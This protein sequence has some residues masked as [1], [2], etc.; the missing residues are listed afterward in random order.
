MEITVKNGF[1]RWFLMIFEVVGFLFLVAWVA[2]TYTASELAGNP[3]VKNLELSVT[4]DP[5]NAEYRQ[6][7]GLLYEYN[8][9]DVQPEKALENLRRTVELNPYDPQGWVDL[10]TAWTFQGKTSEAEACD[11]PGPGAG[12]PLER[13]S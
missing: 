11:F 8:P 4:L 9:Q 5:G 7:L 6:R 3:T 10:G 13:T 12:P 2:K 1:V